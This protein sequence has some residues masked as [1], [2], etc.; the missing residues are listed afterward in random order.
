[1][2]HSGD[3]LAAN[4]RA[5]VGGISKD[6][7]R[8]YN[9]FFKTTNDTIEHMSWAATDIKESVA[10]LP[11]NIAGTGEMLA[12]EIDRMSDTMRNAQ[13]AL[14]EAIDRLTQA[15]YTKQ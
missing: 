1:M 3:V 13:A 2:K 14:D 4:H 11:D 12:R 10:G 6:I 9:T 7:D 5:L 15:L 8:A